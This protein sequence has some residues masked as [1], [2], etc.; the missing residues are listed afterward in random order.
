MTSKG[1]KAR[2]VLFVLAGMVMTTI[3][4]Y[5]TITD[6]STENYVMIAGGTTFIIIPF[7][8]ARRDAIRTL[9]DF[10]F[11]LNG[12]IRNTARQQRV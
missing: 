9:E 11:S 5:R 8:S 2:E 6:P 3:G 10:Q 1:F 12:Y 7:L 4:I